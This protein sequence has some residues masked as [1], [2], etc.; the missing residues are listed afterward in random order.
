MP[1][2]EFDAFAEAGV[3]REKTLRDAFARIDWESYR[4]KTVHI[5]GCSS[6]VI[7]TGGAVSHS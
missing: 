2:F 6:V 4:D 7:P 1:R 3:I 5:Q